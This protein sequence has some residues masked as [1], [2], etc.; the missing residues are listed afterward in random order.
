[1]FNTNFT[2]NTGDTYQDCV[3]PV[4]RPQSCKA[5]ESLKSYR[6]F[7]GL[8]NHLRFPTVGAANKP[9]RRALSKSN[10]FQ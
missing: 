5:Y 2:I 4:R 9:F 7:D 1:M 3:E 8:C 6:R 10:T